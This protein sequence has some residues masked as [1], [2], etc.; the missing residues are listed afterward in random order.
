MKRFVL[1][2]LCLLPALGLWQCN[3]KSV[4][5]DVVIEEQSYNISVGEELQLTA[6]VF[7]EDAPD[8]TIAWTSSDESVASVDADGTVTGIQAGSATISARC[9]EGEDS[10]TIVVTEPVEPGGYYYS[11][12]TWS[13]ELDASKEVTGIVFWAGDPGQDDPVLRKDFPACTHGLA[14]SLE[15]LDGLTS[16]Q[17]DYQTY[18]DEEEGFI[19]RWMES[20]LSGYASISSSTD[21]DD[22]LNKI[23]GYNNTKVIEAFNA[24][25]GNDSWRV[26]IIDKIT[27]FRSEVQAPETSS[28]WYLPSVKELSLLCVGEYDG[29][30]W[31]ISGE[32]TGNR[33]LIEESIAAA[34]GDLFEEMGYWSSTEYWKEDEADAYSYAFRVRFGDGNTIQNLKDNRRYRVRAVLAF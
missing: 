26:N 14:V 9:G 15:A 34:G 5:T 32:M 20:A 30:I 23:L 28:G 21:P 17:A 29:N 22:N 8:K 2:L 1:R 12:G 4:V 18:W 13:S 11:D 25:D 24:A 6:S 10:C 27:E 33:T 3:G 7:P 19:G 31:D 16:W